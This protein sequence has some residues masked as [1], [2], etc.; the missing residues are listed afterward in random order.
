MT[1][2]KTGTKTYTVANIKKAY[3]GVEAD[4]RMIARLTDKWSMKYVDKLFHDIITLAKEEYLNVVNITL[5]K[6]KT[7]EVIKATKF[8]VERNGSTTE[9][10]RAGKNKWKNIPD[11]YLNMILEHS[12]KWHDLSIEQKAKFQTEELEINWTKSTTN[13][14]FPH[15]KKSNGQ[16]YAS[17]TF[18]V[19]KE[20][21]E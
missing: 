13:T 19:H 11:T 6:K 15:L 16:L 17:N 1:F 12:Q 3:E 20:N 2:T 4:L 14:D 18:E 10:E 9:S 5:K 8:R 7:G 21:Y